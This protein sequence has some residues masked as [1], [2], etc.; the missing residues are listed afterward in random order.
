M[1]LRTTLQGTWSVSISSEGKQLQNHK[2][3]LHWYSVSHLNKRQLQCC[4]WT[5]AC[6]SI[7]CLTIVSI[8]IQSFEGIDKIHIHVL[9]LLCILK[10]PEMSKDFLLQSNCVL[11]VDLIVRS[12]WD[13]CDQLQTTLNISRHYPCELQVRMQ[14]SDGLESTR[15]LFHDPLITKSG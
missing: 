3:R 1:S 14:M 15:T 13:V 2:A 5:E 11:P 4:W 9:F 12:G 8:W 6:E 10:T 7:V